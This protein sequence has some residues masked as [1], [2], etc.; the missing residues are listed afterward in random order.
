MQT[1]FED[2][3]EETLEVIRANVLFKLITGSFSPRHYIF[4]AWDVLGL[5]KVVYLYIRVLKDFKA[6]LLEE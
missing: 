2:C 6:V 3:S 1:Q 4:T 5:E